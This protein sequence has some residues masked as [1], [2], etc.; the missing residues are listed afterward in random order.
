MFSGDTEYFNG[1]KWVRFKNF[2]GFDKVL[3]FNETGTAS[4]V[5]PLGF[6]KSVSNGGKYTFYENSSDAVPFKLTSDGSIICKDNGYC[7]YKRVNI[8]DLPKSDNEM[9]LSCFV[10][11]ASYQLDT[12]KKKNKLLIDDVISC[13]L[14][15]SYSE[16]PFLERCKDIEGMVI[17]S[18]N[19]LRLPLEFRRTILG[20]FGL[21]SS[22]F[23]Y[24]TMSKVD[25]YK[26]ASLYNMSIDNGVSACVIHVDFGLYPNG[27]YMVV[28]SKAVG[29]CDSLNTVYEESKYDVKVKSGMVVVI[30]KGVIF[31]VGN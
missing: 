17:F 6:S 1:T 8:V 7:K 23:C 9:L 29:G 30:R 14:D 15:D 12:K 18:D 25:A 26:M 20:E 28:P 2:R 11:G 21:T 19:V 27:I 22:D 24:K 4:L 16:S 10:A 13:Y 3:M 5:K 31:V